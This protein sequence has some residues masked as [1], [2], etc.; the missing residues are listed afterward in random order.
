MMKQEI[1]D[2]E[3]V[4]PHPEDKFK[5][6]PIT[7]WSTILIVGIIFKLL[8]WQGA[9]IVILI[10]SASFTGYAFYSYLFYRTKTILPAVFSILSI[11]WIAIMILG[12]VYNDGYPFNLGGLEFFFA[13]VLISFITAFLSKKIKLAAKK[14]N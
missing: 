4:Q 8:N 7:I 14:Q 2:P 9:S 1:I 3:R 11:L 5:L 6:W 10:S 13:F 12:I